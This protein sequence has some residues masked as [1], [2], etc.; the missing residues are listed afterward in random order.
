MSR[1]YQVSITVQNVTKEDLYR[2]EEAIENEGIGE[3]DSNETVRG[4]CTLY[5]TAEV[6]LGGGQTEE[7]YS[8]D[9][10]RSIWKANKGYCPVSVKLTYLEELPYE[11]YD[12]G[13]KD[14]AEV[15]KDIAEELEQERLAEQE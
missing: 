15:E 9:L 4:I 13:E 8:Q 1:L 14:Y 5:A 11:I 12:L 2:V 7:E 6:S 10:A 3:C